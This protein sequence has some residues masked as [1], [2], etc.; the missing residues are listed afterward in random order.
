M[1]NQHFQ[2]LIS[3]HAA[4]P[5]GQDKQF[6]YNYHACSEYQQCGDNVTVFLKIENSIIIDIGFS[7]CGCDICR[8]SASIMCREMSG[9]HIEFAAQ[10][11]DAI[12]NALYLEQEDLDGPFAPLQAVARFPTRV[13]CAL[14]PWHA[15]DEM[16]FKLEA[17]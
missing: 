10:T 9:K 6:D 13:E 8:A 12:Q 15:L 5:V 17:A 3:H 11:F 16:L 2:Q 4:K 7:G 14:L 1:I